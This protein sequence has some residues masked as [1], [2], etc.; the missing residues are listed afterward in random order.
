M[1]AIFF[2]FLVFFFLLASP[3]QEDPEGT[4]LLSSLVGMFQQCGKRGREKG[5]TLV[6]AIELVSVV[7]K[8]IIKIKATRFD[9]LLFF[10]R[11]A[12]LFYL[13]FDIFPVFI[14]NR[15]HKQAHGHGGGGSM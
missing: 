5:K 2:S 4:R 14:S 8:I 11:R 3:R 13:E 10:T 1:G 12:L 15:I 6:A 7:K 9:S